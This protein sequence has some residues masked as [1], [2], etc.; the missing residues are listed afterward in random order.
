MKASECDALPWFKV[1]VAENFLRFEE[2]VGFAFF[3]FIHA[4]KAFE[5][6]VFLAWDVIKF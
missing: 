4:G 6:Q 5:Q 3:A 1:F 2:V